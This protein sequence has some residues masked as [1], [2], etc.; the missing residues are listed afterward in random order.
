MKIMNNMMVF[1]EHTLITGKHSNKE[2]LKPRGDIKNGN[3]M[4]VQN[5][6]RIIFII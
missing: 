4:R 1:F 3:K 5:Q 6:K 2:I